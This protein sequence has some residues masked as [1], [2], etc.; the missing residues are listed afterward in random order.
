MSPQRWLFFFLS[1]GLGIALGL[2]Y[3]WV[4]SPVEYIDTS[5]DS[6]RIDYRTDYILMVAEIYQSEQ[7]PALA[8]RRLA[9]LGSVLP[10]HEI[11]AQS[12]VF[13]QSNQ[14]A[15]S[16]ILLLQNLAVALQIHDPSGVLP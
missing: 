9:R 3:G 13:A 7:D 8:A 6:L 2:L 5:P 10:A 16:D 15:Q 12:L 11:V 14:Y 1:I 4:I